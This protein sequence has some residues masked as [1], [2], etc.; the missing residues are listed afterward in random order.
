MCAYEGTIPNAWS[1]DSSLLWL[2][3]DVNRLTGGFAV[4]YA[5]FFIIKSLPLYPSWCSY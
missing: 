2:G 3:L 1:N 4:V 5:V